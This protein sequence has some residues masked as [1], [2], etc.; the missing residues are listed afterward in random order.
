MGNR[1]EKE[2]ASFAK[3]I[4]KKYDITDG[5][6]L[7]EAIENACLAID[8]ATSW[9]NVDQGKDS[10]E[11]ASNLVMK[12]SRTLGKAHLFMSGDREFH[13][14]VERGSESRRSDDE[15]QKLS[16]Q[17]KKMAEKILE[18]H[19]KAGKGR[20]P[21]DKGI[22]AAFHIICQFWRE[23]CG[24]KLSHTFGVCERDSL[25]RPVYPKSQSAKFTFAV[26]RRLDSRVTPEMH[27]TLW[28]R[29]PLD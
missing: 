10:L 28:Q 23:A 3:R 13:R 7:L 9:H 4:C 17:T 20:R 8:G 21:L 6:G 5:E 26:M 27:L 25:W 22:V 1:T 24:R 15:I 18:A 29:H 11:Q 14:L 19:H 16:H 2:L 12:A